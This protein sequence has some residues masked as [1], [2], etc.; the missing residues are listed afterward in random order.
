MRC[1]YEMVADN[2]REDIKSGCYRPGE[3]LPPE[4]DLAEE[5][6]VSRMTLRKGVDELVEQGLLVRRQGSGTY[7]SSNIDRETYLYIGPTRGH[8]DSTRYAALNGECQRKQHSLSAYATDNGDGHDTEHVKDLAGEASRVICHCAAWGD[9]REVLPPELPVVFVSGWGG[10][11]NPDFTDRPAYII[12]TDARRASERAT[13]HL[14]ELGHEEICYFG[15]GQPGVPVEGYRSLRS[16]NALYQSH[17]NVL[18]E[19][20]LESGGGL[21]FPENTDDEQAEAER[22]LRNFIDERGGWPTAFV[23]EGDFRA[24]PLIRV[25]MRDGLQ[26]PDDLSIVGM[27]NTP[28]A[29]MLTPPLTSV[30]LREDK[31]ARLAVDMSE[32]PPPDAPTVI[33]LDP[34]LVKRASSTKAPQKKS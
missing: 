15:P 18:R 19:T 16:S 7:V 29:E 6:G 21:G 5:H 11:E 22:Y 17:L 33:R 25:A 14:I 23:C 26:L 31:I 27:C 12:S 30:S 2:I 28:W 24:A 13:R 3:T 34:Q 32:N 20:G 9:F 4:N 1:K 10:V 8:L